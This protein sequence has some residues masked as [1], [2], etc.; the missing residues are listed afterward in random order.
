MRKMLSAG[1][2]LTTSDSKG[3]SANHCAM[4]DLKLEGVFVLFI[5]NGYLNAEKTVSL[6]SE[7]LACVPTL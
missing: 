6:Q 7:L 3:Q 2:D 5:D 1:L 4:R